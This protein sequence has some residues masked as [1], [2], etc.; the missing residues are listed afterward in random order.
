MHGQKGQKKD[1]SGH[2]SQSDY[3]VKPG[4]F[5]VGGI[6]VCQK[7]PEFDSA[8]YFRDFESRHGRLSRAGESGLEIQSC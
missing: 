6:A 8:G 4:D 1:R 2:A 7:I 3:L 5:G